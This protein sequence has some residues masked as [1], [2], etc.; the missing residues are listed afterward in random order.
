MQ[1]I[2]SV[3]LFLSAYGLQYLGREGGGLIHKTK[4]PMQELEVKVQGGLYARGGE[5]NC[6]ILRYMYPMHTLASASIC[7]L[8]PSFHHQ[9]GEPETFTVT[10]TPLRNLP[11]D[12]YVLIDLSASME[13]ELN[14]L[15]NVAGDIGMH[16]IHTCACIVDDP[17]LF[18]LSS[19]VRLK[20]VLH[21]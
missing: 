13:E 2:A 14:S 8:P 19:V 17:Y 15:K 7:I 18:V 16:N 1:Q 12:L 4:I 5:H 21:P 9:L 3:L 11:L 20:L 10:V 6:G